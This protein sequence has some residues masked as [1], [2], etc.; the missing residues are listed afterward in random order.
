[1]SSEDDKILSELKSQ[2]I[3]GLTPRGKTAIR[4]LGYKEQ[5]EI[6]FLILSLNSRIR[7]LE[8]ANHVEDREG[9]HSH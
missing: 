6:I 2:D 8:M 5:G 9:V 4:E 1:M 7:D 3:K